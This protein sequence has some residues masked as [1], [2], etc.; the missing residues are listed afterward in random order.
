MDH[1]KVWF[2]ADENG[3][4]LTSINHDMAWVEID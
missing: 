3:L 2:Q 1:G 4:R